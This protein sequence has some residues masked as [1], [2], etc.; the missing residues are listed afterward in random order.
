MKTE[1]NKLEMAKIILGNPVH[2]TL[3]FIDYGESS[4]R[5][6]Q[7]TSIYCVS[8]AGPRLCH[9]TPRHHATATPMP[10]H[11]LP[12]PLL[13]IFAIHYFPFRRGR[14]RKIDFHIPFHLEKLRTYLPTEEVVN[15]FMNANIFG[16]N[17]AKKNDP[18]S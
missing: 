11:A 4:V 17:S 13:Y 8:T 5:A 18:N 2:I 7:V 9:A 15:H 10:R 3:G 6:E 1:G 12:P 14:N 16:F